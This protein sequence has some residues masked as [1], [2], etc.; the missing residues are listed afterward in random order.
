MPKIPIN[1]FKNYYREQ[2]GLSAAFVRFGEWRE[3]ASMR[4]GVDTI[5]YRRKPREAHGSS[6][7]THSNGA[8]IA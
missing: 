5:R 8:L 4:C 2:L 7:S 3:M 1:A 6:P